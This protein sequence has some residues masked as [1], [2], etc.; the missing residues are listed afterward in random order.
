MKAVLHCISTNLPFVFSSRLSLPRSKVSSCLER[1]VR[2]PMVSKRPAGC[3]Q[4]VTD[5]MLG[6]LE[7]IPGRLKRNS[8]NIVS[9][10]LA[11]P[12]ETYVMSTDTNSGN[13]VRV[14]PDE[15]VFIT[16]QAASGTSPRVAKTTSISTDTD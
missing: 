10:S 15:L 13:V 5:Y 4:T 9:F 14:A 7:D 11:A 8:R 1:L 6:S 12:S 2:V 3:D 16:L